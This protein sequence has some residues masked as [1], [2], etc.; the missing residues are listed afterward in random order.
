MKHQPITSRVAAVRAW[1]A[2]QS[3][4]AVIIPSTD[5]HQSEYPPERYRGRAWITGFTGSAGTAVVTTD[6]A[7][8][9][10]DSRYFLEA[11]RAIADTPFSLHRL[12]TPGTR[13]VPQ[14]LAE[15]L[16][17]GSRVGIDPRTIT[18]ADARHLSSTLTAAGTELIAIEDPLIEAWEDRPGLPG[19]PVWVLESSYTGETAQ[20]RLER[21]RSAV[22]EQGGAAHIVATLD[23]IAWILNLRG[24]DVAYNPVFLA[25]LT[26]TA[27]ETTL[28]TDAQRISS[29]VAEHLARCGVTLAPYESFESACA[30]LPGPVLLDPSRVSWAI[31]E[32]TGS[33]PVLE[34]P[35]PSVM[36]KAVKNAVEQEHIRA[37][38]VRDGLAMVRFLAWLE[39]EVAAGSAL[40]EGS[41]AEKL[42]QIR[43][44]DPLYRGDSFNYISGF[45]A[46]GA[47]VH[48]AYDPDAPAPFEQ[49][50]VYLVDSGGQ[51][52]DGTTD[53][54]RTVAIGTPPETARRD[55]TRVL[56]GHIALAT[57]H[58]AA[59]VCG[60][61]IDAFARAPMWRDGANYGH[62]TGHGVGFALNVHEG[63]QRIAP[64][65]SD[66]PLVAGMLISNEPGLYRPGQWGIR[67]ENLVLVQPAGT[68]EFGEFFAFETVTLCPIDR[69][70]ILTE[71]LSAEERTWIDAYH[72]RVREQLAPALSDRDRAWLDAATAPL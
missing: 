69:R 29:D 17:S 18:C 1:M 23:D 35:Q 32:A 58:F 72:A 60:R 54:T 62:G 47:I 25:Y 30:S 61:D 10:T 33:T 21:V 26:V 71:L 28:Y 37:A 44:E 6:D 40:N 16:P 48:Y 70:L 9:W 68:T 15:T 27:T 13:D 39:R 53:I 66:A 31:S 57:L 63:P 67:I 59:G 46:N 55:F 43:A 52:R 5:P 11:E 22:R 14:W 45:G 36:M 12:H 49:N 20:A 38:M 51:Y 24:T 42:Q 41:V 7:G 50:G 65:G 19:E 56:Q 34:Q 8:L 64:N 4:D 2:R 3:L